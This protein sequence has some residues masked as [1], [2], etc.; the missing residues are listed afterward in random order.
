MLYRLLVDWEFL[1]S[2][3]VV[4]SLG[5]CIVV[6]RSWLSY[7]YV[8]TRSSASESLSRRPGEVSGT[9]VRFSGV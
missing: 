7:I 2:S 3:R 4:V 6:K 5:Y 8:V 9:V 1:T